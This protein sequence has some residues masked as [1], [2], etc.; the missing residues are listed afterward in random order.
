MD[1]QHKQHFILQTLFFLTVI[2][3]GVLFFRFLLPATLPFWLGLVIA[4]FLR[5]V[6]VFLAK[7]LRLKR[8]SVA[9]TILLV[10]YLSLGALIWGLGS[11]IFQ[12]LQVLVS[13]LPM[14]YAKNV[15]PLLHDA[16]LRFTGLLTDLPPST[17]SAIATRVQSAIGELSSNLTSLS[18]TMVAKATSFAGKIPFFLL[19]VGFSVICSVFISMDYAQ[20]ASFLLR[21]LPRGWQKI[22]L[23]CKN[24]AAGTVLRMVRAYLILLLLTFVQLAIGF[25]FLRID[26]WAVLALV[27]SLLDFLPFIGTGIL[28]VPWGIFELLQNNVALGAGL[29]ILY[30]IIAVVRN[31]LEPK[32]VGDSIGLPPLITLVGMYAGM[33]LFGVWGLFLA[34]IVILL[35]QFLHKQGHIRL[36]K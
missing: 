3:W 8:K 25:Y 9:F 2:L 31:L 24:F 18:G 22:F 32:I 16:S 17:A 36:Y 11:L 15:Q 20:V 1:D 34:P 33:K 26:D 5:P 19:T 23:D 7:T 14:M 27:F 10:F 4:F 35:L 12:Q 13:S 29:L 28:L 21:Q 6:T 30:G